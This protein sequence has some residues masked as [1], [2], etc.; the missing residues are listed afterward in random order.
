M[1]ENGKGKRKGARKD[2]YMCVDRRK[3]K[4]LL[5]D[6]SRCFIDLKSQEIFG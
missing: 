6:R 3:N 1:E 5:T 4:D 2:G